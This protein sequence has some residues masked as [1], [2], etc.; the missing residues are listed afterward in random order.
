MK[1]ERKQNDEENDGV[2]YKNKWVCEFFLFPERSFNTTSDSTIT[3]ITT[4]HKTYLPRLFR[5]N[6]KVN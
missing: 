6:R 5:R 1:E 3:I 4:I 2:I